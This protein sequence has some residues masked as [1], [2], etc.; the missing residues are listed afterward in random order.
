VAALGGASLA[1][2]DLDLIA[3]DLL[4]LAGREIVVDVSVEASSSNAAINEVETDDTDRTVVCSGGDPP[5]CIAVT[6]HWSSQRTL[7][8]RKGDDP[9]KHPDL[10]DQ[11]GELSLSFLP[12]G[13][14][15]VSTGAEARREDRELAGIFDW[16]GKP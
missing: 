15:S 7:I 2:A 4:P 8:K 3:R 9:A 1:I 11:E 5:T 6:R 10:F 12:E 16:P 13:R 14:I